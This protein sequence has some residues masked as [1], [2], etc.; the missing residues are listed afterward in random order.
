M[1]SELAPI[2]SGTSIFI[3][4]GRVRSATPAITEAQDAERLGFERVWMCE[5]YNLKEAGVVLSAC[6][7]STSRI[8]VAPGPVAISARPPIVTAALGASMQS[9]Y[10]GRFVLGVGRGATPQYL[11]GHGFSQV[12][13]DALIDTCTIIKR[14]WRGESVTY[15]GPAGSYAGLKLDDLPEGDPPEIVFLH[16]GGPRASRAAA[17][18]VFDGAMLVDLMS[19]EAVHNSVVIM[20][21]ECERLGRDPANLRIGAPVVTAADLSDAETLALVHARLVLF[22]QIPWA[23]EH[24]AKINGWDV[25]V[26]HRIR[27]HPLFANLTANTADQAFHREEVVEVAKVIPESYIHDAA[28]LGTADECVKALRRYTDAGADEIAFY[29]SSPAQNESLIAAWRDQI[30]TGG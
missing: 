30:P 11:A 12:G 5:R 29:G 15:D 21:E 16:L 28:A 17:N 25:S 22:L 20:R 19:P 14:L 10:P 18:P 7:L 4:G 9:L 8:Q 24:L 27:E 2:A 1:T 3:M 23:G 26:V 13:Y 6:A